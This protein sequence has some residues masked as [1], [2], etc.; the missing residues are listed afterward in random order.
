MQAPLYDEVNE[1]AID[2]VNA[3]AN[4]DEKSADAAYAKLKDLCDSHDG[5]SLDHPLQWEALGDFSDSLE[6]AISAYEKGLQCASRQSLPEYAASIKF[7]M[8]E[9]YYEQENFVDARRLV[10]EAKAAAD[11]TNDIELQAAINGFLDE[12]RN[13]AP[14]PDKV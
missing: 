7:A 6:A 14:T 13:C 9:S 11:N 3:S 10:S 1:L 8:A 4:D 12:I 2:I 5:G